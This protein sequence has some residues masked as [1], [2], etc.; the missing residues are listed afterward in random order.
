MGYL[1]LGYHGNYDMY[2]RLTSHTNLGYDWRQYQSGL[3][4]E[5]QGD[6]P[7]WPQRD[8]YVVEASTDDFVNSHRPF[9]VYYLTIS[10][11]MPYSDNRV[12]APYRDIVRALPYSAVTQNYVAT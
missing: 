9:H 12:V 5:M 10:G 7:A 8:S 11:H 6:Q 3:E 4:L 2:G 1:T